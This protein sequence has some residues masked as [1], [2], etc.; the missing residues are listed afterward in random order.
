[1]TYLLG[2]VTLL[3]LLAGIIAWAGDRLGTYVGR[4]RLSVFGTRPRRSGQII[5][6]LAGVLIMLTTLGVLSVAFRGATQ[7]IFNA[8][9]TQERL[10][11]LQAQLASLEA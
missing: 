5:G 3:L 6:V 10:Q 7:V 4:Q 9:A 1:M 2:L 8:Q 11:N